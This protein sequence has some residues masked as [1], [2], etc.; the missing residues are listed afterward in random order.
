[1]LDRQRTE[2]EGKRLHFHLLTL[3]GVTATLFT[4]RPMADREIPMVQIISASA[5]NTASVEDKMLRPLLNARK[6]RGI[7]AN[8][9]G[10]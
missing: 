10:K 3:D 1:M 8:A 7:T 6:S 4:P 2:F 9:R 5:S